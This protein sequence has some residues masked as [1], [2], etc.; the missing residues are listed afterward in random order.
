MFSMYEG[1]TMMM[2]GFEILDQLHLAA[3]FGHPNIG[4]TV[5][6]RRSAP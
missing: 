1:V 4:M 2:S 6:P 5:Q 3:R